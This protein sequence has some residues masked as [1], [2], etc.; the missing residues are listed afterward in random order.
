[1]SMRNPSRQCF[2]KY[3]FAYF[4]YIIF[5]E[6]PERKRQ[7]SARCFILKHENLLMCDKINFLL[8]FLRFLARVESE[9]GEL[10]V[11]GGNKNRNENIR[12]CWIVHFNLLCHGYWESFREFSTESSFHS[13]PLSRALA[14]YFFVSEKEYFARISR[15]VLLNSNLFLRF[16]LIFL[17]TRRTKWITFWKY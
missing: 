12:T 1:M 3:W 7:E 17:Y 13:G 6:K 8:C 11:W 4:H 2:R 14:K 15:S 5:T 10:W 9:S 16:C